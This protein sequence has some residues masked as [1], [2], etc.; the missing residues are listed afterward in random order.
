MS[1]CLNSI[2]RVPMGSIFVTT[3]LTSVN[4]PE[5]ATYLKPAGIIS[6]IVA[7]KTSSVALLL[8]ISM[9]MVFQIYLLQDMKKNKISAI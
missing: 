4:R 7:S 1:M 8:V 6:R 5:P 2:G 9:M 3:L